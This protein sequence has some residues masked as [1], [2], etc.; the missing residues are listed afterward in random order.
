MSAFGVRA[1]IARTEEPRPFGPGI[2]SG[3]VDA[4]HI[5]LA[6]AKLAAHSSA[7]IDSSLIA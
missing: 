3:F 6:V 5:Q 1:D 2:D 7:V 4:K